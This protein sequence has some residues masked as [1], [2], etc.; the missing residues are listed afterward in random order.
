MLP[1]LLAAPALISA[2][3]GIARSIKQ[4]KQAKKIDTT[5]PEYTIP[6]AAQENQAMYRDLA[7]SQRLPGQSMA[8]NNIRSGTANA[9]NAISQTGGGVNNILAAVGGLN[10]NQNDAMN[11]LAVQGAQMN[12]ANKDKLAQSN[13]EIAGYQNEAFDYNKN[14]PYL[15]NMSRKMALQGS[16][17]QNL[18]NS[19]QTLG[20]LSS[21]LLGRGGGGSNEGAVTNN[22]FSG[23]SGGS[24]VDQ[25]LNPAFF[26]S[27]KLGS[28]SGGKVR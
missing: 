17:A 26:K 21:S 2:G 18:D 1:L 10:K 8:E 23:G 15:Q 4:A 12:L 14:Q 22:Y 9:L 11:N 19:L 13:R 7:N 27:S 25:S 24:T 16:S 20:N 5:R 28:Y 6:G 3:V